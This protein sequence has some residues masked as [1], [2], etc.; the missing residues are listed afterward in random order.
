MPGLGL[1][2]GPQFSGRQGPVPGLGL[3]IG[4]RFSG[5]QGLVHSTCILIVHRALQSPLSQGRH[6]S[7]LKQSSFDRQS[8]L[9]V[10]YLIVPRFLSTPSDVLMTSAD[11]HAS[12]CHFCLRSHRPRDC[13]FVII[14]QDT[15]SSSSSP[16]RL[17]LSSSP[18]RLFRHH[19]P[20]Q[21]CPQRPR[22]AAVA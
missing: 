3:P 13:F 11:L 20:R 21:S 4:P 22:P 18:Q 12:L 17:S 10:I 16:Q 8:L 19:R 1:P 6:F 2:A 5:R 9:L 14:A 15:V 7:H